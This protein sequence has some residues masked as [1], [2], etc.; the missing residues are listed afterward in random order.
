MSTPWF[1]WVDLPM[2]AYDEQMVEEKKSKRWGASWA[3]QSK[4]IRCG[5]FTL[6]K[7]KT[8]WSPE[9]RKNGNKFTVFSGSNL[10]QKV[11][12]P[13]CLKK[14][15]KGICGLLCPNVLFLLKDSKY[16]CPTETEAY[17]TSL[18][19]FWRVVWLFE[20]KK[21]KIKY[22][23]RPSIIFSSCVRWKFWVYKTCHILSGNQQRN[24]KEHL[25]LYL[26]IHILPFFFSTPAITL[27]RA[28]IFKGLQL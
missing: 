28:Q 20:R 16:F 19:C 11:S 23:K 25:M 2:K 24:N 21:K 5:W 17:V 3:L 10:S 14:K 18:T 22:N 12:M 7:Q 1:W 27:C 13:L 26:F 8:N 15:M 9:R 6:Y 4:E